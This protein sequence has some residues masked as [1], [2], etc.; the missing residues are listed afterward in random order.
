MISIFNDSKQIIYF[1][2]RSNFGISQF[3]RAK[4]DSESSYENFSVPLVLFQKIFLWVCQKNN[5]DYYEN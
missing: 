1:F 5:Q 3:M 2:N 4:T